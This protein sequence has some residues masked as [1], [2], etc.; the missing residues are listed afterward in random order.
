LITP[1]Q[2]DVAI[3]DIS[4]VGRS[5]LELL[6]DLLVIRPPLRV[7]ILTMHSEEQYARRAFKAGAAG[8]ITKDSARSELVSAVMN[9]MN[10]GRYVSSAVAESLFSILNSTRT[11]RFM[12]VYRTGNLKCFV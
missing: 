11:S 5:G 7:L 4:V 6:K 12:R 3:L 1:Q 2:W 10:G 8:Y 9:I